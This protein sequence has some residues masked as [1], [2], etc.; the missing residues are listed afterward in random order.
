MTRWLLGILFSVL[1][2]LWLPDSTGSHNAKNQFS[3]HS[4]R[5][6]TCRADNPAEGSHAFVNEAFRLALVPPEMISKRLAPDER[7][8]FELVL[9]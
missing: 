2:E 5:F 6:P 7:S 4:Q 8:G 3:A 1:A 9:S